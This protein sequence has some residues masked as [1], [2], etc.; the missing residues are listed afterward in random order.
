MRFAYLIMA[1]NSFELLKELIGALD[2]QENDLYIHFDAKLHEVDTSQFL[3]I[4]QHS[5]L[6]FI[7]DRVNVSWARIS[8]V[9]ATLNLLEA[10]IDKGYD[11][12]HL[13]S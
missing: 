6:Y 7:T 3:S 12:Y 8:I 2:S 13:L 1:H 4:P 5:N 10:S 11:Y 9:E